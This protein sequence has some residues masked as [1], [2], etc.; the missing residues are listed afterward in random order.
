MNQK[1][2][3]IIES[4]LN[5]EESVS[6]SLDKPPNDGLTSWLISKKDLNLATKFQ[7]ILSPKPNPPKQKN[8]KPIIHPGFRF[9]KLSPMRPDKIPRAPVHLKTSSKPESTSLQKSIL[10]Q[11]PYFPI[12]H[13]Q[14]KSDPDSYIHN[15][16]PIKPRL[17]QSNE[18]SLKQKRNF[19]SISENS[20]IFLFSPSNTAIKYKKIKK[21]ASNSGVFKN[22]FKSSEPVSL[23]PSNPRSS[24][25]IQAKAQQAKQASLDLTKTS[26]ETGI[27]HKFSQSESKGLKKNFMLSPIFE[28]LSKYSSML[29][30]PK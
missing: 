20:E 5:E 19:S 11:V 18:K 21:L 9:P 26:S 30:N 1:E 16:A 25:S 22:Y 12:S 7:S 4:L 17:D 29:Q 10:M 23:L 14:K 24:H 15:Q 3:T 27:R 6:L 2:N 8:S 28:N 13:M